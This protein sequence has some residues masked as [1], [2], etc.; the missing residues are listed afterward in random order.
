VPRA[1]HPSRPVAGDPGRVP[2]GVLA[3]DVAL[4]LPF[5][6]QPPAALDQPL[7]AIARHLLG[8]RGALGV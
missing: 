3:N 8:L 1:D 6:P 4:E 5:L 2:G 7:A